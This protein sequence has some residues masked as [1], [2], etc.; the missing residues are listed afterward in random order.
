MSEEIKVENRDKPGCL[1]YVIG[2]MSFIPLI[3]VLFGIIAITW[4]LVAK[5]TKLAIVG[6]CGIAVT[7]ILYGALFYFGFVQNG[8]VYDDLREK[9]AETQLVNAVQ[10]IEFYK[11]QN[12]VYPVSLEELRDNLPKN[13]AVFL[14][15]PTIKKLAQQKMYYYKLIDASSYHIRAHGADGVINT[16]DDVIPKPIKNVGLVTEYIFEDEI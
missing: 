6:T 7:V 13:S 1:M 8:G 5:N 10:S 12:G 9:M 14:F 4:G 16:P 3:G 11:V 2:G 15:D